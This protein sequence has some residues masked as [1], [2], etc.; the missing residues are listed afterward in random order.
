[1]EKKDDRALVAKYQS[2]LKFEALSLLG[3]IGKAI[4]SASPERTLQEI[5]QA[6]VGFLSTNDWAITSL[7]ISSVIS[8]GLDL[9]QS[10]RQ[11][12]PLCLPKIILGLFQSRASGKIWRGVDVDGK[13]KA[14]EEEVFVVAHRM[15]DQ[16]N[17]YHSAEK[18]SLTDILPLTITSTITPGSYILEMPTQHDRTAM[19]IF[20]PGPESLEDIQYMMGGMGGKQ[21]PT[22][23]FKRAISTPGGCF[24]LLL[25]S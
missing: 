24:K 17:R 8:F 12:L 19:I 5:R 18:K 25:Q 20:R 9:N 3:S 1:M 10:H 21:I 4:P 11:I 13:L 2:I 14:S 6:F 16:L 22:T 23:M 7:G 15:T